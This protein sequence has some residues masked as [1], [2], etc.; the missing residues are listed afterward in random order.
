M[1]ER[2]ITVRGQEL[3]LAAL[4]VGV[5]VLVQSCV[6]AV[7]GAGAGTP[8]Y[9]MGRFKAYE[10]HEISTVYAATE[11]AM[12][13]LELNVTRRTED[14]MPATIVARDSA[15]EKITI[16]LSTTPEKTTMISIGVGTFGNE[17]KSRLIY[18]QIKKNL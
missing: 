10:A 8:V 17:T 4:L 15:G 7:V 9:V 18:D 12:E 6:V 1:L 14:A 16:M 11:K 5:A 2:R 13:Q 3:L